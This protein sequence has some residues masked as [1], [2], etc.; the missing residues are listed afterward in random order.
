M[1]EPEKIQ[2]G[3]VVHVLAAALVVLQ[4]GAFAQNLTPVPPVPP[5]G[6]TVAA[7]T[8]LL[9]ERQPLPGT[10]TGGIP[11]GEAA[12]AAFQALA[13]A[14]VRTVIDLRTEAE[15]APGAADETAALAVA[16]G[17]DYRRL[18]VA[19]EADLDLA[20]ARALDL[21]LD[22]WARY[23]VALACASGNRAGALLALRAF[24]LDRADPAAALE[25]GRRAGLTKLEP[26]VRQL[27]GLP[28]LPPP[29]VAEKVPAPAAAATTQPPSH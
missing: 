27:L 15:T 12:A 2:R 23:P 14:G 3:P 24:W 1:S 10:L 25:L 22:D 9:N 4:A 11:P 5:A 20:S 16:A 29:P 21:L 26:A 28:P 6:A 17:L 7:P 8:L 18:P 13:A 19:G